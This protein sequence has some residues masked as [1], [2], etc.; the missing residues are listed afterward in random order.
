MFPNI[1]TAADDKY[2]LLNRNN[3]RQPIQMQLPQKQK[4]FCQF[5]S[6]FFKTRL[7][8]EIFHK[9]MTPIADVFP[10]L[11]TPENLVK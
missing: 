8:L 4:T 3:V 1:L 9:K 5:V 7:N 6:E 2:S 11:Q 10:K